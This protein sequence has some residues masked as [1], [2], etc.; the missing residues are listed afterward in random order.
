MDH[1]ALTRALCALLLAAASA[2]ATATPTA[3]AA[4][5]PNKNA[6]LPGTKLLGTEAEVAAEYGC[7][8]AKAS[9]VLEQSSLAPSPLAAGQEFGHRIVYAL[10]PARAKQGVAGTLRTRIRYG[11][12]VV[13]DDSAAYHVAPGRWAVDTLI[14]LPPHAKP[15]AYELE[16]EFASAQ[17]PVR[18][19]TKIPFSVWVKTR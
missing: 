1:S 9:L 5:A 3:R 14:A 10:C 12:Q 7:G 17:S 11:A 19:A 6:Q 18:F 13:V 15:G 16:V 4:Y 8:K 2:C